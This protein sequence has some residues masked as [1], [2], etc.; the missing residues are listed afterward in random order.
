MK[1]YLTS[2]LPSLEIGIMKTEN[3]AV[4]V[5]ITFVFFFL[6]YAFNTIIPTKN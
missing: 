1:I 2:S 4:L 6:N 3:N 5:T